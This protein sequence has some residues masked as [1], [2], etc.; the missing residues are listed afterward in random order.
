MRAARERRAATGACHDLPVK[1]ALTTVAAERRERLERSRLY[2]VTEPVPD[3]L[4]EAALEG[5][6]DLLQLRDK[7]AGDAELLREAARFRRLCDEHGALFVLNDRPD[8]ALEC[9]ADGVHLGQDDEP[10]EAARARVGEELLI[11]L[12]THVSEQFDRGHAS[13]ADYLCAGP[14]WETPT[15]EGRPAAGLELVRHAARRAGKPWFAIG[16]IDVRNAPEVAAA[17]AE[18]AVVVRAIRDASDPRAAARELR[19]ALEGGRGV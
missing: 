14:V 16:G 19:A 9:G 2:F 4:L 5:G 17:G 8:L 6:A 12:S 11:G 10:A 13:T 1:D 15:K 18:R 3:A 7:S